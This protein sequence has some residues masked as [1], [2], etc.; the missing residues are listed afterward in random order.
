MY[1]PAICPGSGIRNSNTTP[2]RTVLKP[3]ASSS[4]ASSSPKPVAAGLNGAHFSTKLTPRSIT[5]RPLA[6]V[7][8]RPECVSGRNGRGPFGPTNP[9][10]EH[11]SATARS[12]ATSTAHDRR[13][14][15]VTVRAADMRRQ[16]YAAGRIGAP[17]RYAAA[18]WVHRDDGDCD[19]RA[20]SA[21]LFG[22]GRG[23]LTIGV[24][25]IIERRRLRAVGCRDRAPCRGRRHRRAAVA[26]AGRC[27]SR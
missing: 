10:A 15:R 21:S 17:R 8:H 6:S 7:N 12:T 2:R 22:A 24:C 25:L 4:A 5:T 3:R 11:V 27:R 9:H 20:S 1:A 18:S 23:R 26:T 16:P 19:D 14:P 13:G